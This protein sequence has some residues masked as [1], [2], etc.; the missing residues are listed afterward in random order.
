MMKVAVVILTFF[1]GAFAVNDNP[2][3]VRAR[4]Y[5]SKALYYAKKAAMA[6]ED[7]EKQKENFKNGALSLNNII[8]EQS[9][10]VEKAFNDVDSAKLEIAQKVEQ[11]RAKAA[12]FGIESQKRAKPNKLDERDDANTRVNDLIKTIEKLESQA[13]VYS[14]LSDAYSQRGDA[15]L[16]KCQDGV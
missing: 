2:S 5:E 12:A 16:K 11:A 13:K 15:I 4:E 1:C 9:K 8:Q 6:I 3:C 14:K 7:A 10:E